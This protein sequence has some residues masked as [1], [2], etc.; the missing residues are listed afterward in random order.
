MAE[1]KK[2]FIRA[3]QW[4]T[5]FVNVQNRGK[6][7]GNEALRF[8]TDEATLIKMGDEKFS[9]SS[10]WEKCKRVS[11]QREKKL[12]LKKKLPAKMK[13]PAPT[14][15]AHT[16]APEPVEELPRKKEELKKKLADNASSLEEAQAILRIR[17]ETLT[18][19][20]S[21]LEKAQKA[22]N[23]A[24]AEHAKAQVAA[25]QAQAELQQA[26]QE[27]QKLEEEI[28]KSQV[29]LVAPW[30]SG[31][32]PKYGTFISTVEMEGV[33]VRELTEVIEP[34]IKDMVMSGCDKLSDY[35][36][37]LRFVSLVQEF[38]F[39]GEAHCVLN[40]D[41]RVQKLLDKYIG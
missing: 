33:N 15:T 3:H 29:Y 38:I 19:A 37:A 35:M 24:Q 26:R 20:K 5:I 10:E 2:I 17:Q 32:L 23:Q 30:F 11:A 18:E 9:H 16:P 12:V 13:A 41:Q 4:G 22:F 40:T 7:L 28:Q 25:Q 39:N 21:V 36:R 31:T 14:D 8:G 6:T 1:E 27:L 34:D